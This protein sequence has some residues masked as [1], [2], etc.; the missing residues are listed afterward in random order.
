MRILVFGLGK[1][2]AVV[3]EML[4]KLLLE[5]S[6]C[7]VIPID[8]GLWCHVSVIGRRGYIDCGVVIILVMCVCVIEMV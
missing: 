4:L 7:E 2:V 5:V 6:G 8:I 3:L 1:V